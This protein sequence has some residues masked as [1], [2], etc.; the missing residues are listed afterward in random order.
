M[1]NQDE[2]ETR[3]GDTNEKVA[4]THIWAYHATCLEQRDDISNLHKTLS[5]TIYNASPTVTS[6]HLNVHLLSKQC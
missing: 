5:N 2:T 6:N 3:T 4:R 1:K